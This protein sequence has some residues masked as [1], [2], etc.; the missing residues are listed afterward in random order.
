[1]GGRAEAPRLLGPA[2]ALADAIDRRGAE[3][4]GSRL[5]RAEP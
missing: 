3:T 4:E 2:L 1:M 5:G